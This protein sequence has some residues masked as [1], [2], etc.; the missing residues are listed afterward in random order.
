MKANYS[1]N[2]HLNHVLLPLS[3]NI[4]F[5]LLPLTLR[6][7]LSLNGNLKLQF[8]GLEPRV[9]SMLFLYQNKTN[10]SFAE[11]SSLRLPKEH[12]SFQNNLGLRFRERIKTVHMEVEFEYH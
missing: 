1:I 3:T 11:F 7:L 10:L 2:E 5:Q 6:S 12:F 4:H 9:F 8:K